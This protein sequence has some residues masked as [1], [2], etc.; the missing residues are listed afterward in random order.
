MTSPRVSVLLAT[1]NSAEFLGPML[2]SL[3]SQEWCDFELL[4]SDDCST[5][6][7]LD[8][9][10]AAAPRFC[11]PPRIVVRETPSG[12]AQANFRSL[13]QMADAD[14]VFLADHDDVWMP[15]KIL[16]MLAQIRTL[17]ATRGVATPIL[18][19]G[20][21][22]VV[23][24]RLRVID[25]S[26]WAFKA[27]DPS[28]GTNLRTALMHATVTGCA[29]AFNRALLER[30]RDFPDAV[31]MHDWWINL[32]AAA[33]GVVDYDPEPRILY[34]QHG[35]NV[36]RQ[37]RTTLNRALGHLGKLSAGHVWVRKRLDQGE[38]FL[39]H[40]RGELPAD[41]RIV[42]EHFVS[43]RDAGSITRRVR[44]LTGGYRCPGYWRNI[45]AVALV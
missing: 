24:R 17:E 36:S 43:I 39:A 5:D 23:D 22:T 38:L 8:I 30:V 15:D 37:K 7:T 19:H 44:M 41:A 13:L 2:D 14:Y 20:D 12:S 3:V 1:R 40:F 9:L 4:V 21:L 26:F 10:R 34:R 45:A 31:I 16:R 27:I 6:A 35:G 11:R 33:F 32:T 18:A 29:C 25:P 42:L 28:Y